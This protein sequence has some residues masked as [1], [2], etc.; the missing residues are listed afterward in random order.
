[1]NKPKPEARA[2]TAPSGRQA[3][4]A[5]R[6]SIRNQETANKQLNG[7]VTTATTNR[8]VFNGMAGR[9]ISESEL[10]RQVTQLRSQPT[11]KII[12]LGGIGEV[13]KNLN[14]IEFGDEAL[15]LDAGFIL[16]V[17]FPGI[18]YAIP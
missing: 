5:T 4:A 3:G 8:S 13:G 6:A 1:M 18:N 15:I 7:E 14:V 10:N 17:D 16:G 2:R 9:Q 11:L 12:P